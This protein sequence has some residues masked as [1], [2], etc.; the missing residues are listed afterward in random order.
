MCV[1]SLASAIR[2]AKRIASAA[3]SVVICGL[4]GF[5]ILFRM[6]NIKETILGKKLLKV[7][8]VFRFSVQYLAHSEKNYVRYYHKYT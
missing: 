8:G 6:I 1:C 2:N 5:I 7:N 3:C 4:S